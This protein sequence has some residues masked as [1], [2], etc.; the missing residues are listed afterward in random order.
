VAASPASSAAEGIDL[1]RDGLVERIVRPSVV[2]LLRKAVEARLLGRSGE[3]DRL[4]PEVRCI[5]SCLP[6][7]A[8]AQP[9]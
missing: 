1:R 4:R 3:A 2:E 8:A 6:L 7:W 9:R 5:R